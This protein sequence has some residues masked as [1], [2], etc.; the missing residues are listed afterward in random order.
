MHV[1]VGLVYKMVALQGCQEMC[2][3][4]ELPLPRVCCDV[5]EVQDVGGA[6]D[7]RLQKSYD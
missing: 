2:T 1:C 4:G 6:G 3:Q 7:A 5:L